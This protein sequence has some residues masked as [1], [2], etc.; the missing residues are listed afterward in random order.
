METEKATKSFVFVFQTNFCAR[1][2][3]YRFR[4]LD[5]LIQWYHAHTGL[6]WFVV[7]IVMFKYL[8]P[9][10]P[11]NFSTSKIYHWKRC[12]SQW[13]HVNL[14]T[15]TKTDKIVYKSSILIILYTLNFNYT[16]NHQKSGR[17]FLL[18][19][20]LLLSLSIPL[21][22]AFRPQ[23]EC[24]FWFVCLFVC[25][26]IIISHE[27]RKTK[28]FRDVFFFFYDRIYKQFN[29]YKITFI[30]NT[31]EK[32]RRNHKNEKTTTAITEKL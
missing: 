30:L 14:Y 4:Y 9:S 28:I 16:F 10:A 17:A 22:L 24:K 19:L 27:W 18:T 6:L 23:F 12:A 5:K 26:R 31:M 2:D 13:S 8:P 29:K 3:V 32:V 25:I 1:H 11:C 15:K 20:C 21:S 7:G